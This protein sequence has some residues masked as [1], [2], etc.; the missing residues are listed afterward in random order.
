M[1][2][3]QPPFPNTHPTALSY[4]QICVYNPPRHDSGPMWRSRDKGVR[5]LWGQFG[6]RASPYAPPLK[7]VFTG[8]SVNSAYLH[9]IFPFQFVN[10]AWFYSDKSYFLNTPAEKNLVAED[11]GFLPATC[12]WIQSYFRKIWLKCP[13]FFRGISSG[14]TLLQ[15]HCSSSSRSTRWNL[16]S[17]SYGHRCPQ[18]Y[19]KKKNWTDD[20][21]FR[22][23]AIDA[24]FNWV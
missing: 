16:K 6:M 21:M 1:S 11:L 5:C 22:S 13:S 23:C 15:I 9:L 12:L 2:L 24:D 17:F 14:S 3:S 19:Q 10:R 4:F 7:Y 18:F 8:I 20:S